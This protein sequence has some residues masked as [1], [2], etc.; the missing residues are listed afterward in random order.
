MY[1][2]YLSSGSSMQSIAWNYRVGKATVHQIVKDTCT[3]LWNKLMPIELPEPD[4]EKF[5]SIAKGFLEKWNMPNCVGAVDGK[6]ISIQAPKNSG[7]QFFNYKKTFSFVLMAVCDA[8]YRFTLVDIGAF[9]RNHDSVV[10]NESNFGKAI[11]NDQLHLPLATEL[12][13]SDIKMDY[14]L[15]GDQAFPLSNRIMRPYPGQYLPIEKNIFNYRLSRARRTIENAFGILVQRFRIL[16]NTLPTSLPVAE[17]I[18]KACIVLHNFLQS[19]A[20]TNRFGNICGDKIGSNGDVIN[21]SWR[22]ESNVSAFKKVPMRKASHVK[23]CF[24]EV[25]NQLC[26][27]FNS[28]AGSVAWQEDHVLQGSL[29]S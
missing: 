9:G 18:V 19:D 26:Q 11:M 23:H 24:Q 15:V 28:N 25:R 14:Y 17:C 2:S 8:H 22:S 7:S 12:P 10:F 16:R 20:E 27:Y 29:P 4:Q 3:V 1:F 6:H 21:G 13:N 5:K